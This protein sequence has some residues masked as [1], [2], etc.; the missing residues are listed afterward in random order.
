[1]KYVRY[2]GE[3]KALNRDRYRV[4]IL[5]EALRPFDIESFDFDG[6]C[7]D[8]EWGEA[9]KYESVQS[10]SATVN[11]LS[12][13]DR[14]FIDLYTVGDNN[15]LVRI[16]RNDRLYWSGSIDPEFYEEPFSD[17]ENYSVSLS[18]F[19]FGCL[20]RIN[21]NRRGFASIRDIITYILESTGIE[22]NALIEHCATKASQSAT[23]SVLSDILI[24]Q[25][26]FFDEDGEP[27][28]MREVLEGVLQPFALKIKQKNGN[29]YVYDLE[30]LSA[31]PVKEV[32]WTDTD[33]MYSVGETYNNVRVS[34]SINERSVISEIQM[35]EKS[36]SGAIESVA[37][38]A[39][40]LE[41]TAF[42]LKLGS[43]IKESDVTMTTHCRSFS[44]TEALYGDKCKGIAYT[45][46]NWDINGQVYRRLINQAQPVT[47]YGNFRIV[48][49]TYITSTAAADELR[50]IRIELPLLVSPKKQPFEDAHI[51]NEKGNWG[52]FSSRA[53]YTFVPIILKLKDEDGKVLCHYN[54][55]DLRSSSG[56]DLSLA[57]WVAG[58]CTDIKAYLAYYKSDRKATS[59]DGWQ[60]NSQLFGCY[61]GTLPQ[62]IQRL[63]GENIPLPYVNGKYLSGMLELTICEGLDFFDV[64]FI[65]K[66]KLENR[67]RDIHWVLYRMPKIS[68]TN[69]YGK[70]IELEDIEY[71]AYVNKHA[72]EELKIDT[73]IG[74]NNIPSACA[75]G[76]IVD[77]SRNAGAKLYRAGKSGSVENLLIGTIY[78]NYANRNIVLS[79]TMAINPEFGVLTDK[80]ERRSYTDTTVLQHLFSGEEE[81]TMVQFSNDNYESIEYI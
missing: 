80:F 22:Y 77:T 46:D 4:D 3:F 14:R 9:A 61:R 43:E 7:V 10:S 65:N 74:C 5:Q 58:D 81:T 42:Y 67:Y 1:M 12:D 69:Q 13:S 66:M 2:R 32:I 23:D 57:K 79:G 47:G 44:M 40:N 18:F 62:S 8:I 16:Y 30:S 17:A 59:M 24:D 27:M 35:D 75:T 51:D 21:W 31:L 34:L 54:N 19:D 45:V 48:T 39:A 56:C 36:V 6:E 26:N 37:V 50:R 28:S 41:G 20:D 76:Q 71:N 49:N 15:T 25:G 64:N 52:E 72:K 78:S 33:A 60:R 38:V 29:I 73:I 11:I 70:S 68:F 53:I 55:V 63:T